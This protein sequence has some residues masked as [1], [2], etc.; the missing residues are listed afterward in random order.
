MCNYVS[1]VSLSGVH[2]S[3]KYSPERE[4][5][6]RSSLLTRRSQDPFSDCHTGHIH[7]SRVST[8]VCVCVCVCGQER[9]LLMLAVPPI[10]INAPDHNMS[11]QLWDSRLRMHDEADQPVDF[12]CCKWEFS[13]MAKVRAA[14]R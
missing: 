8:C 9:E 4:W 5:I 1:G 2:C 10:G 12:K 6:P 3:P 7:D 11:K 14:N 13:I